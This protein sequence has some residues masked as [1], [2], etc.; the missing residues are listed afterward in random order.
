MVYAADSLTP[1]LDIMPKKLISMIAA[2]TR[3]CNLVSALFSVFN[4]VL[5]IPAAKYPISGWR[6]ACVQQT[7]L[8]TQ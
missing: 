1:S 3:Q 5:A 4:F 6:P 8:F 2:H 7:F